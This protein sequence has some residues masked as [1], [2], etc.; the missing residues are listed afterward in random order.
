[1]SNLIRKEYRIKEDLVR[2]QFSP[3]IQEYISQQLFETRINEF[4][5]AI[6]NQAVGKSFYVSLYLVTTLLVIAIGFPVTKN[7]IDYDGSSYW[8]WV[9][10]SA[11]LSAYSLA[12]CIHLTVSIVNQ[13]SK[14]REVETVMLRVNISDNPNHIFWKLDFTDKYVMEGYRKKYYFVILE[15]SS[16][17]M[18]QN[19][20]ITNPVLPVLPVLT[21]TNT[22]PLQQIV[23]LTGNAPPSDGTQTTQMISIDSSQLNQILALAQQQPPPPPPPPKD[24][25]KDSPKDSPKD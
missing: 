1:M 6:K 13:K 14:M 15:L 4:N 11:S 17:S 8:W 21:T 5:T 16:P 25:P 18:A 9:F 7:H 23:I 3:D 19:V 22:A 2:A 20:E 24:P 10:F 12:W